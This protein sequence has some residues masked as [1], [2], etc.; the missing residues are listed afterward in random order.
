[1]QHQTA[2][3]QG[4]NLRMCSRIVVANGSVPALANHSVIVNQYRANGN[5][6]FI[7]G[8]LGQPK[9]MAHPVFMVQFS[10]R[11]GKHSR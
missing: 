4:H 5:L 7:P 8:A 6:T 3:A 11:H 9:R 2:L 10:I 1:L